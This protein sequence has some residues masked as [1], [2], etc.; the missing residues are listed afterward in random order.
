MKFKV[1]SFLLLSHTMSFAI[2]TDS[3]IEA[4]KKLAKSFIQVCQIG[5]A[6]TDGGAHWGT[7]VLIAP[8]TVLTVAHGVCPNRS[9]LKDSFINFSQQGED[10]DSEGRFPF[11][12]FLQRDVIHHPAHGTDENG[13]SH[14]VDLALITLSRPVTNIQPVKLYESEMQ[15]NQQG[16]IVGYGCYGKNGS[17]INESGRCRHFGTVK[18]SGVDSNYLTKAITSNTSGPNIRQFEQI[19]GDGPHQAIAIEGDSGSPFLVGNAKAKTLSVAGIFHGVSGYS[20]NDEIKLADVQWIP[21][22]PH[23]DWIKENIR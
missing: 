8:N 5:T 18:L 7:G 17:L 9:I 12:P 23:L 21:I 10:F 13:I 19:T 4:S 6:Y 11:I 14:G 16:Y 15:I 3:D 22:Y 20:F 1:L 2:I